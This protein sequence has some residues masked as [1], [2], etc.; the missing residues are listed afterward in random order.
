MNAYWFNNPVSG[1][2]A[3]GTN[4]NQAYPPGYGFRYSDER[5]WD[6]M[7][8]ETLASS[9]IS[10]NDY[11]GF[12]S[13]VRLPVVRPIGGTTTTAPQPPTNVRIIR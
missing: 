8:F 13:A 5:H 2:P 9:E 3:S 11:S 10:P 4:C 7:G 6:N 1:T 12:A